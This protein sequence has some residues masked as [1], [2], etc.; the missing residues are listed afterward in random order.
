MLAAA[1]GKANRK[2]A[3]GESPLFY[4]AWQK[5]QNTLSA[6]NRTPGAG[7]E[8]FVLCCPMT[9]IRRQKD[10]A[11]IELTLYCKGFFPGRERLF[12]Q[13]SIPTR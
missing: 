1:L 4:R 5:I 9:L 3:V 11:S 8:R 13:Y 7:G 12:L 10:R 6:R 2:V